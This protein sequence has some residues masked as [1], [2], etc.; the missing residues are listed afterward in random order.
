MQVRFVVSCGVNV[1][2]LQWSAQWE[3]IYKKVLQPILGTDDEPALKKKRLNVN[4]D[5][6]RRTKL[7]ELYTTFLLDFEKAAKNTDVC[8]F[9]RL[10]Y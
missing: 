4:A 5:N 9:F 2:T 8:A 3:A 10:L 7:K 1:V 6:Q